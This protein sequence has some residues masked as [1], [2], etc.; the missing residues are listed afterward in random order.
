MF[1]STNVLNERVRALL[2][3]EERLEL[4]SALSTQITTLAVTV[5]DEYVEETRQQNNLASL[6]SSIEQTFE[7]L[8]ASIQQDVEDAEEL[9]LDEQ[10]RRAT[11]GIALARMEATYQ[12]LDLSLRSDE[13]R[14]QLNI[15]SAKFQPL[16]SGSIREEQRSRNVA[17]DEISSIRKSLNRLSIIAVV[18]VSALLVTFVLG[19]VR[20]LI[21]RINMLKDATR[22]IGNEDFSV[23]PLGPGNDEIGQLFVELNN[24]SA[25]LEERKVEVTTEWQ[26]LNDL[27]GERTAEL[28]LANAELAK[29]DENR[30]RFFS[31]VSHEMRTPLTVIIAEAELGAAQD[32]AQAPSF[33]IIQ[34]RAKSLNRRVD[35]LLRIARSE[36]GELKIDAQPFGLR[37]AAEI[38]IED[39]QRLIKRAGVEAKISSRTIP[40]VLGDRNWTRQ[41]ISAGIENALRHA[42]GVNSILIAFEADTTTCRL[43]LIDNGKGIPKQELSLA[44]ER[45]GQGSAKSSNQG[46]GIGLSFAQA[47]M[48]AQNGRLELVSPV[49]TN[50]ALDGKPGT[51]LSLILP[52]SE[53]N[54]SD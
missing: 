7:R 9:G 21:A 34:S 36:T 37:E 14:Q 38:A 29:T 15:F 32:D 54:Y 2:G 23:S 1:Y 43:D 33:G 39:N 16:L 11:S 8:E 47:I 6:Q 25:R 49:P 40:K 44:L 45:Y 41:V 22:R 51:M 3:A 13:Q 28:K 12:S 20:P 5:L 27:I 48:D 10:S 42:E 35:D 50:C 26:R 4:Y 30:R 53:E 19:L 17:F 18:A 52:L 46:F 24:S 31:D